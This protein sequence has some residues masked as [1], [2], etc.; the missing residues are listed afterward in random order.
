MT[1]KIKICASASKM[2]NN[3]LQ[4]SSFLKNFKSED[5][6]VFEFC[7]FSKGKVRRELM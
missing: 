2:M 1:P 4:F 7:G 6:P 3:L 5:S